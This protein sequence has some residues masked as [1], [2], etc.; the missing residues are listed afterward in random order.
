L[1]IKQL[2]L[3]L[4]LLLVL[5]NNSAC[6]EQ[7]KVILTEKGHPPFSFDENSPEKGIYLDILDAISRITGDT[8]NVTYYPAMRK[9][10]VFANGQTDIEPGV[11]PIWRQKS[12]DVSLY[13][14]AFGFSTDVVF[15]RKNEGFK[16]EKINDLAGKKV[17]TVRGYHY[18]DYEQA[19]SDKVIIRY[20]TNHEQELVQFLY[21][22]NR[23]A[24]AGF[25][26]KHIL[27]YYMK[28]NNLLFDVGK[29]IDSVP[30]MFRFHIS[31]KASLDKFNKTL[32]Q[33]IADGTVDA[34]YNKY[35]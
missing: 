18:P 26:N 9:R 20:D 19:F 4:S 7:F 23:G 6:A 30:V 8:F 16:V 5:L 1:T 17:V 34:I 3:Y 15:F 32:S 29:T 28:R 13:S 11:N 14:H 21:Q 12:R 2:A 24:D 33:L 35:K 25:I 22:A 31:K 10:F 27:F